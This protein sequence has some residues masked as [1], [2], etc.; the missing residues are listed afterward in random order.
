MEMAFLCAGPRTCLTADAIIRIGNRHNLIAHIVAKLIFS[1]KGFF[2]K[3]QY[4]PTANLVAAA[5]ADA[6]VHVD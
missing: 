2:D 4:L 1:L 3:F 6:F 5:T